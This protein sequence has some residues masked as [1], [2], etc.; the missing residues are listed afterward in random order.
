L[1]KK[2]IESSKREQEL[3]DK[4]ASQTALTR[5]RR[6]ENKESDTAKE[7]MERLGKELRVL[8]NEYSIETTRAAE[9]NK[10]L[11]KKVAELDARQLSWVSADEHSNK[12]RALNEEITTLTKR[13]A[14][15]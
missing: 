8:K 2:S 7:E 5:S 9:E 12:M 14:I 4:L 13:L 1:V 3:I 11:R 6:N 10:K 15:S